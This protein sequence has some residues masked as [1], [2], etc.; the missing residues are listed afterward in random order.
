MQINNKLVELKSVTKKY[1]ILKTANQGIQSRLE[2][3]CAL[4]GISLEVYKGEILGLIGRNGAGKTTL[5]NIITGVLS[6][7]GGEAFLCGRVLGLFNLGVGFQ[8]ELTGR[9]NVFLN[10]AIIGAAKRELE[11]KLGEIIEFSELGDFMDMPLGTYS[12]GMRLRLAFSIIA[13]ID[14][15][16]LVVDEVLAVGDTLFQNKC[17]ERLMSFK[18]GGK[19]LIITTQSMDLI[20]RLCDRVLLLDHGRLLFQGGVAEGINRYRN[21]LNTERF[22]VGPAADSASLVENTK[23]WADNVSGWGR[24]LGAKEV[25]IG[26]VEAMDKFGRR[27]SALH[28]GD[29]LKVKVEFFA[30]DNVKE[31]HFGAAI[32]RDDGV[33]CYGPNTLFDGQRISDMKS[34][35]GYFMLHYNKLL[36]APGKYR[37]SVAVWDK[38]E[39]LAFDYHDGCYG[40][41][42]I[43]VNTENSLSNIPFKYKGENYFYNILSSP[44]VRPNPSLLSSNWGQRIETEGVGLEDV[45]LLN[46]RDEQKCVFT[47]D[48]YVKFF[49]RFRSLRI[50]NINSYIWL[51]IY[52]D[53][54]IYCQGATIP[55]GKKEV[56]SISFPEFG[57]L[58]GGY[59]VSCGVWDDADKK[60]LMCHHGVYPFSMTFNKQDHGTVYMKHKWELKLPGQD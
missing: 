59:R 16:I 54:G 26:S 39:T 18:R 22:F 41:E 2:D 47:T 20:E 45:K 38:N 33:Y 23:R 3:F 31:P 8:D 51:G 44:K 60:F 21:L 29:E 9:E 7:T 36:L 37:L 14:F 34:G 28:S 48:E 35:K 27:C 58:P 57:F 40:L 56:F 25:V 10:G 17:F 30:R 53:D 15:D 42:V 4:E 55:I 1:P 24:R 6:P 46:D 19:T 52:R 49:V 43:G 12:Q 50:K 5:L 32:F 11:A 13:N